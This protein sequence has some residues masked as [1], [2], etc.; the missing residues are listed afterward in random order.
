MNPI[1]EFNSQ[2]ELDECLKYWQRILFL[3]DWVIC[4]KIVDECKDIN[5]RNCIATNEH[6][7]D[8]KHAYIEIEKHSDKHNKHYIKLSQEH[9]LIHE[10]LHCNYCYFHYNGEDIDAMT[11][12][13]H[14]HSLLEQMAK[15]LFM[16]K[17]GLN[18][19]WFK[20]F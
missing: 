12:N 15:S 14:N 6:N 9:S 7:H 3:D 1:I 2:G 17:Y 4:A 11:L 10:L 19:D 5:G 18:F 13:L 16:T 8:A 20:N